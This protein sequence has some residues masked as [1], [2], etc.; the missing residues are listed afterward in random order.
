MR[1]ALAA[2]HAG[3]VIRDAIADVIRK[4]GHEPVI[5][6]AELNNPQD[7]YPVFAQLVGDALAAGKASRAVLVCGSGAGV[8]VAANK[9]PGVRATLGHDNY[10]AHQMVEHDCCN[11]MTLGARTIGEEVAKELVE[12]FILAE[13]SGEDRHRRRLG[14]VLDMERN[15]HDNPL[16]QLHEAGQSIWLDNIRR[17][18]LDSG[19]LAR[20]ISTL[21]VTGLTSNPTIFEHAIAGSSDYDAAIQQ[22][23]DKGLSTEQLFFELAL[24]DIVAAADLFRPIYEATGG[25]DGF[26]SLEVSP[27]L[28][29][30]ADGTIAEAKR[31]HGQADRPNVFIKVPGTAAGATAIEALIFDGIPVNVTL[32][33]SREHYSAAAEAYMRGLERRVEANL[34]LDVA[35]VASLFISRWDVAANAKLPADMHNKLG[36]A[37]GQRTFKAYRDVLASDRWGSL[38]AAGAK[39]QRLLW[40]STSAKDPALPDTFYV[41]AL[42]ADDTVNTMPEATLLAFGQHGAV[43]DL[44]TADAADDAES[45]IADVEKAGVSVDD[46]GATLQIQGRDSF[47]DSFAQL[48]KSIETKAAS[49]SEAHQPEKEE[50]GGL[51]GVADAATADLTKRNATQRIWS[52]DYTLWGQDPTEIANRL[53]WLV[54]PHEMA[55]QVDDLTAF[56]QQARDDGFTHAL[57]SGMGGSSLFPQVLEQAFGDGK[58]GLDLRVLD[59][60]DPGTINDFAEALPLDKT[61]LLFASKSGGTLET[62]SHLDYFWDRLGNPA[63]FAAVTDQGTELDKLGTERGFRRVFHNNPDIGGR[64]SALSHFGIVPGALMGVDIAELLN[65]A[66]YMLAAAGACVAPENNPALRFGAVLGAAAKNGHDKCTLLIPDEIAA[67][68]SWLEQLIAESTGKHGVGI[69]PVAGEDLGPPEVYGDDR[70]FVSL[71]EHKGTDALVAAGHPVVHL[72][73]TDRFSIGNEVVRWEYAIAMAGIVLGINPFDQPNVEAAKAAAAKVLSEGMPDI[74]VEPVESV[75]STVKAGDYIAIQAYIDTQSPNIP[76][77][78][79]A[80]MNLRDQYRV[81]TTLGIGPRYLHST[82]QLHKGGAATG[83]FLQAVGDDPVDLAIPGKP[84]GFS[85]LKHAQAAGDY[86][87]LKDKG[88]RVARVALD[89]LLGMGQ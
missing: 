54:S 37:I 79:K 80:R 58:D 63:Q 51:A 84:F 73:Y 18:L 47:D 85:Q 40:A 52:L 35:S 49:L 81:A 5:L 46:L 9:L 28:A 65:R 62:R 72:D 56:T 26:V 48:L 64:Y 42:A 67:F 2:D 76:V 59:T 61:L 77:L 87:A 10:T 17:A 19:T 33:F 16:K 68:S 89:E 86:L 88:L 1:I 6:G 14:E 45:V 31:L 78:Q 32:L 34:P 43:G 21:W 53:G 8:T 44:L 71:G 30:D 29:D 74:P 13:F 57:W 60:S 3:A 75:L 39:P 66:G 38:A 15:Q 27:T 7:D 70:I 24:E 12:A 20:Y 22:R 82:G 69:L 50:L 11:V 55:E 25:T 23:L 36:V 41:T 83:V 4:A